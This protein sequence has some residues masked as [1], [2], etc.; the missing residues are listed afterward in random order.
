VECKEEIE[1]VV[2]YNELICPGRNV[3]NGKGSVRVAALGIDPA[4]S[5]TEV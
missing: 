1:V 5:D 4:T 3:R 2:P